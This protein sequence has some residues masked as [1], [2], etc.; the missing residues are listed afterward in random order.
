[1]TAIDLEKWHDNGKSGTDRPT[2]RAGM[3]P[4]PVFSDPRNRAGSPAFRLDVRPCELVPDGRSSTMGVTE[5]TV[6][7]GVSALA[8]LVIYWVA[9][10]PTSL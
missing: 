9:G 7:L 6:V 10:R 5:L 1:M 4:W 8:A 2:L 3:N